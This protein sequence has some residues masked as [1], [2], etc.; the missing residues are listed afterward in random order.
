MKPRSRWALEPPERERGGKH[1]EAE[2]QQNR[3]APEWKARGESK[4]SSVPKRLR[5]ASHER[6]A[7]R[8]RGLAEVTR[9]PLDAIWLAEQSPKA[10]KQGRISRLPRKRRAPH[11]TFTLSLSQFDARYAMLL[12]SKRRDVLLRK[13]EELEWTR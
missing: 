8:E 9:V 4:P 13:H 1:N 2:A 11:P 7:G 10:V 6:A 3:T 5:K 12:R